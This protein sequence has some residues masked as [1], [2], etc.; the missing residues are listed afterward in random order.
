MLLGGGVS[1]ATTCQQLLFLSLSPAVLLLIIQLHS[2]VK[3]V[4][5]YLATQR[6]DRGEHA[7]NALPSCASLVPAAAQTLHSAQFAAKNG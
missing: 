5:W 3:C 7:Q 1:A 2:E 4:S 6:G